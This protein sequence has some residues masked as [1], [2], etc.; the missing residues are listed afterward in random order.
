VDL[1]ADGLHSELLNGALPRLRLAVFALGEMRALAA[2]AGGLQRLGLQVGARRAPRGA[3]AAAGALP[4]AYQKVTGR[5]PCSL[6]GCPMETA[7]P[8]PQP[9][10]LEALE[11]DGIR[12]ML[13]AERLRLVTGTAACRYRCFFSWLL[14]VLRALDAQG[15]EAERRGGGGGPAP[16]P[17][18]LRDVRALLKGQLAHDAIGPELRVRW[19]PRRA[20]RRGCRSLCPLVSLRAAAPAPVAACIARANRPVRT[21]PPLAPCPQAHPH[22]R[23]R[24]TTPND[25]TAPHQD[26]PLDAEEI[27]RADAAM[28]CGLPHEQT[29]RLLQLLFPCR[30]E[31]SAG[32]DGGGASW[33]DDDAAAAGDQGR[34]G[35]PSALFAAASELREAGA[36]AEAA[37]ARSLMGLLQHLSEQAEA[38]FG[39][40]QQ[41]LS[42]DM[43]CVAQLQV[44]P[45]EAL[46]P[47]ASGSSSSSNK[48]GAAISCAGAPLPQA[49]HGADRDAWFV[50][51]LPAGGDGSN[52]RERLLVVRLQRAGEQQQEDGEEGQRR[53]STATDNGG[54]SSGGGGVAAEGCLIELQQ[55]CRIV[56]AAPYK[57]CQ[58]AVLSQDAG[59]CW[60]CG[61]PWWAEGVIALIRS[62]EPLLERLA[63]PL[64]MPPRP[65]P[66]TLL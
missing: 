49:A 1:A 11:A 47:P 19:A 21:P 26:A 58:L 66:T 33:G 36:D 30:P 23:C 42:A 22:Q 15:G 55:G 44:A 18:Q 32:G 28:A 46:A 17:E 39:R 41:I 59:A 40:P 34:D 57:D 8:F 53:G 35:V 7:R 51:G 2:A 50:C 13:R 37:R 61:W 4:I 3:S 56:D 5:R 64:S 38:V 14:R 62:I 27:A 60:P 65:I 63:A 6:N 45:P 10:D 25:A 54:G 9:H 24:N 29:E 16:G 20:A 52:G 48:C 31:D 43:I 12:A